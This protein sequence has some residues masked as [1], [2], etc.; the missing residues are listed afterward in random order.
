MVGFIKPGGVQLKK[1]CQAE[2]GTKF[3]GVFRVKNHDFTPKNHIFSNFRVCP[4]ESAPALF[5]AYIYHEF[6]YSG[7]VDIT[8]KIHSLIH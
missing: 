8:V 4:P 6:L 7:L 5:L 3:V 1:L 2:E